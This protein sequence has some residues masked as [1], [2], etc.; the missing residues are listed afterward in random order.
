MAGLHAA[1]RDGVGGDCDL[2]LYDTAISM[3]TYP[4]TWHLNAGY[5]PVRTNHSAHPSLVPFQAFEASDGWLVVGCAKEK[6]WTRLIDVVGHPDWATTRGSTPSRPEERSTTSYCPSSRSSSQNDRGP[7]AVAAPPAGVPSGPINDVAQA[8]ARSHTPSH[9]NSSRD[10]ASGLAVNRQ[11]VSPV[12]FGTEEITHRRAPLRDEDAD[13]VLAALPGY[14]ADHIA[15]LADD[16]A[17]G[18]DTEIDDGDRPPLADWVVGDLGHPAHRGRGCRAICWMGRK[19]HRCRFG[20][21]A[22]AFTVARELGGPP[23]ATSWGPDRDLRARRSFAD[24]DLVHALDFDDT[25]AGGWCTRPPSCSPPPSRSVRRSV[26]AA[27]RSSTPRSSGTRW[28]A[29]SRPPPRTASTAGDCTPRWSPACSPRPRWPPGSAA[30]TRRRPRTPSASPGRRPAACW[31]SWAPVPAPSSSTPGS[32]RSRASSPHGSPPPAPPDPPPS[33]TGPTGCT[34]RSPTVL[35]TSPRSRRAS[36][37]GGRRPPSASSPGRPASSPT[38][39]WPP[40]T[41]RWPGLTCRPR[42]SAACTRGSTPTRPPSCA[43]PTVT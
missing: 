6:F 21:G 5:E 39:R 18:P 31:P 42:A 43:T 30:S 28:R 1:R 25:H 4:A 7:L 34:T 35:S 19:C 9:E 14:T 24:G 41:T 22:A 17:F 23:Q 2:S 15:E 38:R 33:S 26:R 12:R 27:A 13:H 10:R 29:G 36:A 20:D 32:P 37:N 11:V 40:L 3:L 16:G 8:L